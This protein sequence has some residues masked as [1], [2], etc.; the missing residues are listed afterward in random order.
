[1]FCCLVSIYHAHCQGEP[2]RISIYCFLH[3]LMA[4]VGS[5]G[6]GEFSDLVPAVLARLDGMYAREVAA[7][8]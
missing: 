8:S 6:E 1:M 3:D 4:D 2:V 7:Q 5:E